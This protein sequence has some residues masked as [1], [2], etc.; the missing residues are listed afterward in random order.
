M[1]KFVLDA[2]QAEM[3][4]RMGQGISFDD[5]DEAMRTVREV[6]P[7]GHFLGTAHT[8][9]VF[10]DAFFMPELLDNDSFEQWRDGGAKD[11][12]Q[13]A[14]EKAGALLDVPTK[15]CLR[16][17]LVDVLSAGTAAAYIL[18]LDLIEG[19]FDDGGHLPY[20]RHL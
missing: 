20:L 10:K 1:S 9:R 11:A 7:G 15:H 4:Y 2:E 18:E 17:H 13:R 16:R 8:R 6:G 5:L 19:Q 14:I 3:Y 12:N